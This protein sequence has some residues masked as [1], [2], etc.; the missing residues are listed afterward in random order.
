VTCGQ[1]LLAA[2][3]RRSNIGRA[4]GAEDELA[5]IVGRIG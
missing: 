3:L 4:A 2:R 1:H 5:R